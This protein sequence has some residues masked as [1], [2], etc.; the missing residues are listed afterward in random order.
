VGDVTSFAA[1]V[2]PLLRAEVMALHNG[3]TAPRKALWSHADPITLFGAEFAGSG[4]ASLEPIFDHLATTFAGSRD[5]QY[6]VL[7]ADSSGDLGYM[8]IERSGV[9]DLPVYELWVTT[10]FRREDSAWKVIHRH[11]DPL[12]AASRDTITA[13]LTS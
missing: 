8:A 9:G 1:E 5:T 11:A 6:E 3:D 10:L 7:S 12:T 4:W 2:V 13:R